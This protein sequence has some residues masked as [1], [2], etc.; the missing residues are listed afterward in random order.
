MRGGGYER[1]GREDEAILRQKVV[2]CTLP[3]FTRIPTVNTMRTAT[4]GALDGH[5]CP[6]G[7]GRLPGNVSE[8][9]VYVTPFMITGQGASDAGSAGFQVISAI[10]GGGREG[11]GE[12]VGEGEVTLRV[13]IVVGPAVFQQRGWASCCL[14]NTPA[15]ASAPARRTL[16]VRRLCWH[17]EAGTG[18]SEA[19]AWAVGNAAVRRSRQLLAPNVRRV[20][21][22]ATKIDSTF[23]NSKVRANPFHTTV[24]PPTSTT[25]HGADWPRYA[26]STL[27]T[28]GRGFVG[29]RTPT[30]ME[31]MRDRSMRLARRCWLG[32]AWLM[33][34][35]VHLSSTHTHRDRQ[36]Q[37]SRA[38]RVRHR[39]TRPLAEFIAGVLQYHPSAPSRGSHP[40]RTDLLCTLEDH[41]HR[42]GPS[43]CVP[44]S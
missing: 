26:H 20:V 9:H 36:T 43:W 15:V 21:M 24:L 33:R 14:P 5:A 7:G 4:R 31:M 41:L 22:F 2:R 13:C 1:G 27:R 34:T 37:S 35:C 6:K 18:A 25:A 42:H 44:R 8:P 12:G 32:L 40:L 17:C 3:A 38:P 19:A 11:N 39:P 28:Q 23:S 30:R 16:A 29:P 10:L